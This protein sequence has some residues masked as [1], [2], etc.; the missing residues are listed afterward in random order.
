MSSE[1]IDLTVD[2]PLPKGIQECW[3]PLDGESVPHLLHFQPYPPQRMYYQHHH[4]LTQLIHGD[5]VPDFNANT[6]LTLAPPLVNFTESY[7]AA[8]KAASYPIHSFTVVPAS[9]HPV[10]LPTWALDYWREIRRARG[11]QHDWKK[12]IMWLREVSRLVNV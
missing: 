10:K 8:I 1:V 3:L 6:L 5:G 4:D 9:G 12:A 2:S 7:Q 11:Y